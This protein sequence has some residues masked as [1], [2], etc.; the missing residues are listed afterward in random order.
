[1]NKNHDEDIKIFTS[2]NKCSDDNLEVLKLAHETKMHRHNGNLD[3]AKAFGKMVAESGIK[4]FDNPSF[5]PFLDDAE[6]LYEIKTLSLFTGEAATHVYMP[7]SILASVA[8][9]AMY[10]TLNNDFPGFY[11]DI[12]DGKAFTFY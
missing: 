5:D 3:K 7:N 2:K 6:V 11:E 12:K 1:M 4:T 10:D 9:N 8:V